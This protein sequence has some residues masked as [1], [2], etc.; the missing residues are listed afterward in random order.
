MPRWRVDYIGRV[1]TTLGSVEAP[2]EK[3]AIAKGRQTVQHRTG[4]TE[5]DRG[6]SAGDEAAEGLGPIATTMCLV[7]W[8]RMESR[9]AIGPARPRCSFSA[10]APAA[11]VVGPT[12]LLGVGVGDWDRIL[13]YVPALSVPFCVLPQDDFDPN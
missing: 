2:D 5:Q 11:R 7:A 13:S 9:S 10:E 6:H 8:P 4:A 1:R 12:R 3:S